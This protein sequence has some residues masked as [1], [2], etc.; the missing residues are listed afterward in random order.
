MATE[1]L[2]EVFYHPSGRAPHRM[3]FDFR[4]LKG[5]KIRLL[6]GARNLFTVLSLLI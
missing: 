5:E 4:R 6:Q 2:C 3:K 1:I